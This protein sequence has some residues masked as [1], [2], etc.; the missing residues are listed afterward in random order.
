M[1]EVFVIIAHFVVL[2]TVAAVW[3][4]KDERILR[5]SLLSGISVSFFTI[6]IVTLIDQ[7]EFNLLALIFGFLVYGLGLGIFSSFS[8]W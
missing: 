6:S 4:S 3:H 8:A 7:K 5:V 1:N 2:I